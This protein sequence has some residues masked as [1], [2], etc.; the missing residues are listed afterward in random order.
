MNVLNKFAATDFELTAE[1]DA[2]A[3]TLHVSL[4]YSRPSIGK[5]AGGCIVRYPLNDPNNAC[6]IIV[7][8]FRGAGWATEVVKLTSV[9]AKLLSVDP[10]QAFSV[11]RP[12]EIENPAFASRRRGPRRQRPANGSSRQAPGKLAQQTGSPFGRARQGTDSVAIRGIAD[13]AGA[14]SKRRG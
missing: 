10:G 13:V 2:D 4:G 9:V 5:R 11:L 1:Y 3:D 6:G 14:H 8:E 12:H 7:L